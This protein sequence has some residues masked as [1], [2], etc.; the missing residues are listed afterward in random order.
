MANAI[1]KGVGESGI[2]RLDT[3]ADN[4]VV[5]RI[6]IQTIIFEPN[7]ASDVCQIENSAEE[8]KLIIT[9]QEIG[10]AANE[11]L[12]PIVIPFPAGL[13]MLG[14]SLGTLTSG[15]LVTIVLA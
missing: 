2:L 14:L 7:A 5:G 8:I 3:A 6:T 12:P 11:N 4:V 10:T 1:I 13:R 15:A 9:A